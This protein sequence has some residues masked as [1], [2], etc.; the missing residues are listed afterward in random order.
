MQKDVPQLV[1]G[2]AWAQRAGLTQPH[3]GEGLSFCS[4]S[5]RIFHGAWASLRVLPLPWKVRLEINV[6]SDSKAGRRFKQTWSISLV[7]WENHSPA[8]SGH[9]PGPSAA[10]SS[11]HLGSYSF[12]I[13]YT[14]DYFQGIF[15]PIQWF[16]TRFGN[17][18]QRNWLCNIIV[19]SATL[20]FSRDG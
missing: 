4:F 9:S 3:S 15:T 19:V 16:N 1:G 12:A 11:S 20:I 18:L 17:P 2:P 7:C 10:R 14:V 8:T 5:N 6:M 13:H